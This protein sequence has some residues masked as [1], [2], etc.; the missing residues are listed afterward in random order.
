MNN[1]GLCGS[2]LRWEGYN[3][4][5]FLLSTV[6]LVAS[7]GEWVGLDLGPAT[8]PT[9]SGETVDATAP[10]PAPETTT[11]ASTDLGGSGGSLSN[12]IGNA[13][14]GETLFRGVLDQGGDPQATEVEKTVRI[15]GTDQTTRVDIYNPEKG[16]LESKAG[17]VSGSSPTS[18]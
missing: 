7:E 3:P 12:D 1:P 2:F 10:G 18:R 16:I 17:Y 4:D 8:S 11:P 15:E 9:T 6:D 14:Q 13:R 5:E